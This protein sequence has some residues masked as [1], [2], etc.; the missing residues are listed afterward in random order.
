MVVAADLSAA[1]DPEAAASSHQQQQAGTADP[2]V[3][4][5]HLQQQGQGI[6]DSALQDQQQQQQQRLPALPAV[7]VLPCDW[8]AAL[9]AAGPP[10]SKRE[11]SSL[12]GLNPAAALAAPL[13]PPLLPALARVV[14][15]LHSWLLLGPQHSQQLADAAAAAAAVEPG[16]LSAAAGAGGSTADGNTSSTEHS[17]LEELLVQL[18][19]V[20]D[21]QA[22]RNSEGSPATGAAATAASSKQ[23]SKPNTD[24]AVNSRRV[25][26]MFDSSGCRCLLLSGHG[27]AGQTELAAAVL[28]LLGAAAAAAVHSLSLPAMLLAGD[29]GVS[30]GLVAAVKEAAA[31]TGRGQLLVLYLPR[32]EVGGVMLCVYS[33]TT[34]HLA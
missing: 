4:H 25:I 32:I 30:R 23:A 27:P 34:Q 5:A 13:L 15:L 28:Q 24:S 6:V 18:G 10:A 9:A 3:Q 20:E 1:V 2:A 19:T 17:Q 11:M 26:N 14:L 31:R 29:G 21:P 7:E 12:A 22:V 16:A 33:F 8:A